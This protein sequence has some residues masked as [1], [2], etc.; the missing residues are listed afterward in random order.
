M[1]NEALITKIP[2]DIEYRVIGNALGLLI[3]SGGLLAG[4]MVT[5]RNLDYWQEDIVPLGLLLFMGFRLVRNLIATMTLYQDEA[6]IHPK[7][8]PRES[9]AAE[10]L[11]MPQLPQV[12]GYTPDQV[13]EEVV[14]RIEAQKAEQA[15]KVGK[16]HN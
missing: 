9:V 4:A 6:P 16:A 14:K 11:V 1:A 15:K 13:V 3:A 8:A 7:A 2:H 5:E 10:P 12:P